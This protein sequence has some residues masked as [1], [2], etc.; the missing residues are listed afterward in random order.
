MGVCLA[1]EC[2]LCCGTRMSMSYLARMNQLTLWKY[3]SMLK[4][5][6]L[7][8]AVYGT[9]SKWEYCGLCSRRRDTETL[10]CLW[11]SP[12]FQTSIEPFANVNRI[13]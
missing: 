2:V 3:P 9:K 8:G 4:K 7:Q 5:A 10:E 1:H 13:R 12:G 6:E 11:N